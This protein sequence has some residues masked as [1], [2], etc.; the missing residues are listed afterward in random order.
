MTDDMDI[1]CGDVLDG[2]S[3]E[4]KGQEPSK[5]AAG[6]LRLAYEVGRSGLRR[7]RLCP[8]KSERSCSFSSPAVQTTKQTQ[9]GKP[10]VL[11]SRRNTWS[12][13]LI[14]R[15][16]ADYPA[17]KE[18]NWIARDFRFHTGEVLPNCAFTIRRL[19]SRTEFRSSCCMD[20]QLRTEHAE[21]CLRRKIV[22]PDNR[23]M[24]K[25]IASSFPTRSGMEN[26]QSR[27]MD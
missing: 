1:N 16:A 9:V 20:R 7:A 21:P 4:T 2:T 3:I 11:E 19:V 15:N 12:D 26:R 18:G 25:S 23:S 27:R 10:D 24:P 13:D 6:C 5:N 8:G 14:C 17:P 22:G